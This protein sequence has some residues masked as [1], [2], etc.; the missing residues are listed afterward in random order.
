MDTLICAYGAHWRNHLS[1]QLKLAGY[2]TPQTVDSPAELHRSLSSALPHLLL[3]VHEP[4]FFDAIDLAGITGKGYCIPSVFVSD[5]IDSSLADKAVSAG[6]ASLLVVPA[7]S[8]AIH[9]AIATAMKHGL[10]VSEISARVLQ[11]E[12]KLAERKLI[13]KAKGLLMEK[14]RITE[15]AAFRAIRSRSMARRVSLAKL[16]EDIIEAAARPGLP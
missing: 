7:V 14:E 9:G 5:N 8:S 13:E 2:G 10:A 15:D 3:V 11:L 1:G 6:Y 12:K 16:A 4:P